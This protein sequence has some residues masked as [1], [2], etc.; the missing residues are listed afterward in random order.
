MTGAAQLRATYRL[1]LKA[2]FGFAAAAALVPYLRDLGVSHLYLSPSMQ[3][4]P[5][6]EHGYDVIDPARLSDDLG[7]PDE[8]RAL[9]DAV[10]QAGMG[11]VLDIVPNHM[12]VDDAN[13]YWS[14]PQLRERFF[15]IDPVTGEPRRFFDISDLAGVRQE[16]PE[17]FERTHE[18]VLTLVGEGLV[19]G[20]RIDHPD[21]LADPAGYLA[22]LRERGVS[23]VWVEKILES[24]ERLRDWPVSG[25]VG[26]E[27]L[28][29]ACALFVDPAGE[30]R[31]T[32]LW[33]RVSGDRRSFE[34]VA[35]DAKLEQVGTTFV[36]EL[37]RLA[38]E[39]TSDGGAGGVQR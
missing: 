34:Q 35:H 13:R 23:R 29:D 8:F 33:E 14:D 12:A 4:R 24:R 16:D 37:E 18:L 31:M 39:L 30:A 38:R 27:F 19:D 28:N 1:Q 10:H 36:P 32:A 20:L 5:G 2:E 15:D 21:G 3:A 6:S 9:A 26:Y 17:V 25:T 11:V 7:G 22:R